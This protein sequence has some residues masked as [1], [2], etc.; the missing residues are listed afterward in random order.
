MRALARHGQQARRLVDQNNLGVGMD[1]ADGFV[2]RGVKEGRV[3]H[4][5][6]IAPGRGGG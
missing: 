5:G 1:D 4:T 2:G 6:G 3:G